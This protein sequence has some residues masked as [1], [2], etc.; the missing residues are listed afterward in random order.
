[1][2]KKIGLIVLVFILL[3]VSIF[4]FNTFATDESNE[5]GKK[6]ATEWGGIS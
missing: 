2:K 6:V 4:A 5:D 3:F 1:M